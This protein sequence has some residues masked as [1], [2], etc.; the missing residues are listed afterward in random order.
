M[1]AFSRAATIALT[2]WTHANI[3][4]VL[5]HIWIVRYLS[6]R[7]LYIASNV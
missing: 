7:I 4:I 5:S 6:L 2:S 3:V 1:E